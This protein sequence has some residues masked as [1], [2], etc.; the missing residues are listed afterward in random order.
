MSQ[1]SSFIPYVPDNAPFSE[2]QRAW[3]NGFLA[4]IFSQQPGGAQQ[5]AAP[6]AKATILFGTQTG[7]A[8][9]LA[10][11]AAKKLKASGVEAKAVDMEG[12]DGASL[13]DEDNVVVITSTY[14]DGEPPDNAAELHAFLMS[15]DA[16]KL[17]KTSFAV[18]GLGDTSYPGFNSCAK[19]FDKRLESLGANRLVDSFFA[20]VEFEDPFEE[21]VAKLG[22][23]LAAGA[24]PAADT[25]VAEEG[26]KF[27]KKNP[28]PSKIVENYN[29][30]GADSKKETRHVSLS[31]E[32]SDLEYEAG[33]A[34]AIIPQNKEELVD[35]FIAKLGYDAAA[36]VEGA[37]GADKTLKEAMTTDFDIVKITKVLAESLIVNSAKADELKALTEDAKAFDDYCWGRDLLDL[38]TDYEIAFPDAQAF[39][40]ALKKIAHR[41]YSISSSPHAH[42][43]EVHVTVGRVTYEKEGRTRYGVCSDYLACTPEG[44]KLKIFMHANKNFR[45]PADLSKDAIMVGPGTGIAPFRAFIE[46][47]IA[48]EAS[49]RNWLFFGDQQ[50]SCDFLYSE[51][52]E[53]WVKTGKL[54][55]LDTAFSRDQAEKIYVQHRMKEQG[56]ELF[57]WLEA[58]ACF[59]VCG[60][61]SRMAKD[62]DTALHEVIAENGNMSADAAADYV[63]KLKSEKRY[64]RDVY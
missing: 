55:R 17:E 18:F 36:T 15:D 56:A 41:L 14:G 33:D 63:K 3:L 11:Q 61:A 47:R 44:Q 23:S 4:G 34:V 43:G 45:P 49:G 7:N 27:G 13:V 39:L 50:A 42:P 35:A 40:G 57:A 25:V 54:N 20:D 6:A 30:N 16:P 28:F 38:F 53:E 1:P 60:D 2:D 52:L 31:L 5:A 24:A 37:D 32:G 29:L 26:P 21:W 62:V 48:K 59:F 64:Q 8:E 22:E 9:A 51:T 19:D 58:G 46:D 12:F 10:S